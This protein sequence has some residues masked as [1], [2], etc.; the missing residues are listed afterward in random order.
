MKK[1]AGL[2]LLFGAVFASHAALSSHWNGLPANI[3]ISNNIANAMNSAAAMFKTYPDYN[4][5]VVSATNLNGDSINSAQ[6]A[7]AVFP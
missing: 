7:T 6:A 1:L 2:F 4:Y 5:E 3:S